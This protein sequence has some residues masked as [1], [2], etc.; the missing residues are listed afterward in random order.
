M[1]Q[2]DPLGPLL[3]AA[4]IQPLAEQLRASMPFSVFYL[5]DGVVGGDVASV[6]QG[7][8]AVQQAARSL[9][10]TLNL[11]KCELVAVGPTSAAALTANFPAQL[12]AD[13]QGNSRVLRNFDLLGAAIGAPDYVDEHTQQRVHAGKQLLD[14]I[15]SLEDPQV[16]LRLLRAC[17]G[18]CRLVHSMRCNPPAA[19]RSALLAF[20]AQ[21]RACFSRVTGLHL[22]VSQWGQASRGFGHAGLGLRATAADGPVAYLASIGGCAAACS[23][24][25]AA[26][27][28]AHLQSLPAVVQ[29]LAAFNEQLV[30]G[31][32]TAGAVLGQKQ[33][34]LAGMVDSALGLPFWQLSPMGCAAWSRRSFLQSSA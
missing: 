27:P 9:G 21:V 28:A 3:F 14:A 33:K 15:A 8:Q 32:L 7:L 5:D 16:G 34:A 2:G 18:H 4:A 30:G 11:D 24:L 31:S 23:D 25:D 10:L 1:Q 12:L 20:D 19:Q 22:D 13:S 29:A 17:A 6:S 26:Y